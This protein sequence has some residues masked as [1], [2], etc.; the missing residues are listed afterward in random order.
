MDFPVENS[1]CLHQ[2]R[3]AAELDKLELLEMARSAELIFQGRELGKALVN[4]GEW[5]VI[6]Q[7]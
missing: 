7:G 3:C 1:R 2:E 6:D 5:L 4:Y